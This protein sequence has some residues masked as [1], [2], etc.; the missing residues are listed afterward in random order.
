[1]RQHFSV[2]VQLIAAR[3]KQ[4][5]IHFGQWGFD[6]KRA[7]KTQ[8]AKHNIKLMTMKPAENRTTS[9]LFIS[10]P[11]ARR[12]ANILPQTIPA[13][14]L[15]TNVERIIISTALINPPSNERIAGAKSTS[16]KIGQFALGVSNG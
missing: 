10:I 3:Q 1:L 14:M 13:K 2:V 16:Q 7:G 11:L 9:P 12:V 4:N 15:P 5:G 8:P 6:F